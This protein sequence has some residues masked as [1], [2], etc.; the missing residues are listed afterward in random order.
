MRFP[1]GATP[2]SL[3]HSLSPGSGANCRSVGFPTRRKNED[4]NFVASVYAE[5]MMV[6]QKCP[7]ECRRKKE[8]E[9]C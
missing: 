9:Y 7:V 5:K 6:W 2:G 3:S 4:N 8:W 1:G